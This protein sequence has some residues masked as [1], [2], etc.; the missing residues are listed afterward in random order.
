[1]SYF[2][3]TDNNLE[4]SEGDI[5]GESNVFVF[6]HNDDVDMAEEDITSVGGDYPF[7]QSAVAID[8][9]SADA[10][11]TISGSGA[12]TVLVTGLDSSLLVVSE[13]I[14][15]NGT[16]TVTTTQ[17]FLRVNDIRVTAV[18]T[19]GVGNTGVITISLTGSTTIATITAEDSVAFQGVYTIPSGKRGYLKQV[20]VTAES[21]KTFDVF[22]HV[23]ENADDTSAPMSPHIIVTRFEGILSEFATKVP[24]VPIAGKADV[25]FAALAGANNTKMSSQFHLRLVDD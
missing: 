1:M 18:G 23:R 11:D 16:S 19:Y 5:S 12:R 17:T 8:L 24:D 15:L 22:L 6:G 9:V 4:A 14:N 21:S 3:I 20:L 7:W 25:W 13:S 2:G 10:N